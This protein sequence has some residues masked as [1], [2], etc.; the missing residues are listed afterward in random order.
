MPA[1][2]FKKQFAPMVEDG[3]K[4]QTIRKVRK[5]PTKPG[6]KLS[7]Y[8]GMRTKACRLL[9]YTRCVDVQPVE[10]Y[11]I[12]VVHVGGSALTPAQLHDFARADG[13]QDGEQFVEFFRQE[14][15][16]PFTG[17]EVIKW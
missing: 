4:R 11:A 12:G 10:V 6:D 15:G 5:T 17:A 3:S 14:Y 9:E 1:Y 13:F 16:L 7:L 8:T 2:N